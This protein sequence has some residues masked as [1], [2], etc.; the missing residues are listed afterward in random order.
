M[1]FKELDSFIF[2][3]AIVNVY[4]NGYAYEIELVGKN[5]GKS[6]LF[7]ATH[8]ELEDVGEILNKDNE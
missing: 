6:I 8:E 1:K 4:Q 7:T 3:G 2:K 5:G